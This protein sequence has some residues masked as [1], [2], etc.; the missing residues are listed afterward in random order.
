MVLDRLFATAYDPV[1]DVVADRIAP[2][3]KAVARALSGTVLDLGTGTGRQLP[4]L[5]ETADKIIAVDPDPRLLHHAIDRAKTTQA[6]INVVRASGES[7]PV[8]TD[9]V[10]AVVGTFV[11]C[12]V[13]DLEQT[14]A[15][16]ERVL[17]PDGELRLLEHVHADGALGTTQEVIE[18]VWR[19]LAGGCHLTR[20]T[21]ELLVDRAPLIERERTMTELRLPPAMPIIRGRFQYQP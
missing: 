2:H 7:L 18:P 16:I 12:S 13:T 5:A 3:R 19:P 14:I 11:L 4:Y 20:R 15:E 10:D 6:T 21:I 17:R 9:S 1:M 8:S